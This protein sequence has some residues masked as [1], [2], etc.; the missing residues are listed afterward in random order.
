MTFLEEEAASAKAL[1]GERKPRC[2]EHSKEGE[3][4]LGPAVWP[5]APTPLRGHP[6]LLH[7]C[8]VLWHTQRF[9]LCSVLSVMDFDLSPQRNLLGSRGVGLLLLGPS[10]A[11]GSLPD[12]K[13]DFAFSVGL[14]A[15]QI[16]RLPPSLSCSLVS[17]THRNVGVLVAL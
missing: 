1:T 4:G 16:S 15:L 7:T 11:R 2:L 10:V 17:I 13:P 3:Q 12:F 6:S 9:A 8:P 14:E 5:D